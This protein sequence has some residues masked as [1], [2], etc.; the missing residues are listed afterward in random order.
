MPLPYAVEHLKQYSAATLDPHTREILRAELWAWQH[1]RERIA[2]MIED[3]KL[4]EEWLTSF[5]SDFAEVAKANWKLDQA[6][7]KNA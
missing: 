4:R 5:D 1:E 7:G 3:V 6:E 2:F